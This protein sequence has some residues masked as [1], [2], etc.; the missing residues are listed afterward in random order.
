LCQSVIFQRDERGPV[1]EIPSRLARFLGGRP[2]VPRAVGRGGTP[3]LDSGQR[4]EGFPTCR[5]RL[6]R[7]APRRRL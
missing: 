3:A 5:T 7:K 1:R 2:R 6:E 4:G